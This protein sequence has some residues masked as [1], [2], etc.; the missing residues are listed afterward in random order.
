MF[1]PQSMDPFSPWKPIIWNGPS[2]V[3]RILNTWCSEHKPTLT[4]ES[5]TSC[6]KELNELAQAKQASLV[7]KQV[8][9]PLENNILKISL[10]NDC[11]KK[12]T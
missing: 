7:T 2:L 11:R 8:S 6:L 3:T 5:L 9:C 1:D 12:V 4:N 10:C